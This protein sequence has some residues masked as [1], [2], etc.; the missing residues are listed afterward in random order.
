M[1]GIFEM[2]IMLLLRII[3]ACV[4]GIAIGYERKNRAKEAGTGP[5]SS[6]GIPGADY[7]IT[8]QRHSQIFVGYRE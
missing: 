6:G 3:I 1:N 5:A 8:P 4:C 2:N 7:G